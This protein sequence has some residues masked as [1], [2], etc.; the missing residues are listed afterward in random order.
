MHLRWEFFFIVSDLKYSPLLTPPLISHPLS[1]SIRLSQEYL[2][3]MDIGGSNDRAGIV[4]YFVNFFMAKNFRRV[5]GMSEHFQSLRSLSVLD[6]KD[7]E[8]I[9]LAFINQLKELKK[10]RTRKKNRAKHCA[11][12]V[13]QGRPALQEFAEMFPWYSSL[14]EGMMN[15]SLFL[16]PPPVKTKLVN[17]TAREAMI[18]GKKLSKTLKAKK[19]AEAG[20]KFIII[21]LGS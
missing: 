2:M 20:G 16:V 14:M 9:G 12:N 6:A 15:N 4:T 18:I 19:T 11:A 3:Q 13:I 21:L 10:A 8:V 7:G 17:M 1:L 5:A